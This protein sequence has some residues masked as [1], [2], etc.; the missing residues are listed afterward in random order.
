MGE[1]WEEV[2]GFIYTD[3]STTIFS[4]DERSDHYGKFGEN[5]G[6]EKRLHLV[7]FRE[8]PMLSSIPDVRD[9]NNEQLHD[10]SK[11]FAVVAS[12]AM[13]RMFVNRSVRMS[14]M[15][16]PVKFFAT[17]DAAKAWLKIYDVFAV[18]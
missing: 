18:R 10:I 2:D 14:S 11:S 5:Y 3:L 6:A 16:F 9:F 15:S 8:L 1:V 4:F 12:L 13:I 17:H 7:P